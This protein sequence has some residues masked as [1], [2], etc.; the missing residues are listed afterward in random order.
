[1]IETP[2]P[3]DGE[4]GAAAT[5][6]TTGY[7]M[8]SITGGSATWTTAWR[9]RTR[10]TLDMNGSAAAGYVNGSVDIA[11]T[12]VLGHDQPVMPITL[13]ASEQSVFFA[14]NGETRLLS[15]G[16]LSTGA[17]IG[18]PVGG[19]N[20]SSPAG[21]FIA[22]SPCILSVFMTRDSAAGSFR[23]VVYEEDGVTVRLGAGGV[24]V[25]S[26][27]LTA[28]NTGAAPITR[29]KSSMVKSAASST[30]VARARFGRPR[31]DT[32]ATGLLPAFRG[33]RPILMPSA[34]GLTLIPMKALISLDGTT[35]QRYDGPL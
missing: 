29:I 20:W 34:D 11:A 17:L 27:L 22:N 6:A 25:D 23:V 24:P 19:G 2:A 12:D 5:V 4:N 31:W 33:H 14:G 18:R 7:G 8:L 15:V 10:P 35:L 13:P 1:M 3:W 32:A 26:G 21:A 30:V 9:S 28:R 16:V